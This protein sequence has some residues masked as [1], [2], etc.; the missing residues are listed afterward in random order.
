MNYLS[1]IVEVSKQA[2]LVLVEGH[3]SEGY[4][5]YL[6]VGGLTVKKEFG[7]DHCGAKVEARSPDDHHTILE[8]KGGPESLE[9]K[10]EC[11]NCAEDNIRYWTKEAGSV[12]MS[13]GR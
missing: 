5:L 3:L 7:C 12:F 8:L 2:F 6:I 10:V 1:R 4:K 9:R 13:T 11:P